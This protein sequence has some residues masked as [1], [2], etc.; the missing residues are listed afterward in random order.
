[1]N[2]TFHLPL[3]APTPRWNK[4]NTLLVEIFA[5]TYFRAAGVREMVLIFAGIYFHAKWKMENQ[6]HRQN[7]KNDEKMVKIFQKIKSILLR[8]ISVLIFA[9]FLALREIARKFVPA[10]ISTNKVSHDMSINL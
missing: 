9:K 5:G 2:P 1:M 4:N 10:K 6:S 3:Q 8:E 7:G